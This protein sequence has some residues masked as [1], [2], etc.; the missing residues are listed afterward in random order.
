MIQR[1]GVSQE[2]GT[3]QEVQLIIIIA[4]YFFSLLQINFIIK[5][6]SGNPNT[7]KNISVKIQSN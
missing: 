3:K 1:V 5:L 7:R 4:V 6:R 2:H